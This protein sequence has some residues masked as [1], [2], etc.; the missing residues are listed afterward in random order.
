MGGM[1]IL[2]FSLN[3]NG[4]G[5]YQTRIIF[6][7]MNVDIGTTQTVKE[8]TYVCMGQTYY[9][10]FSLCLTPTAT[11]GTHGSISKV[12]WGNKMK[13]LNISSVRVENLT[14]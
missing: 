5:L 11:V 3:I 9:C 10:T 7:F 4:S 8:C 14:I 1:R 13:S 12:Y 6:F 2:D